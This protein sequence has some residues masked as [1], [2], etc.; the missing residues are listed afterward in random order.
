MLRLRLTPKLVLELAVR[1]VAFVLTSLL[2]VLIGATRVVAAAVAA[3]S[4]AVVVAVAVVALV[5]VA[6]EVVVGEGSVVAVA[7]LPPSK[8]AR[9]PSKGNICY[10]VGAPF[11]WE[12]LGPQP[13]AAFVRRLLMGKSYLPSG[14]VGLYATLHH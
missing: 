13:K 10:I 1:A 11:S 14:A 3:A 2:L 9:R 12:W 6:V 8:A 5:A 4:A 7:A